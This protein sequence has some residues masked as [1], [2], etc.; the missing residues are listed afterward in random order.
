MGWTNKSTRTAITAEKGHS[1]SFSVRVED[2]LHNSVVLN[3]DKCWFTVRPVEYT[4]GFND[5]DITL[6]T[7]TVLGNGVRTDG[8]FAGAGETSRFDFSV[9]AAELNLDP[10]LEYEYDITFS[11]NGYSMSVAAGDFI[12]APNVT[13]RGIQETFAGIGNIFQVISTIDAQNLLVVTSTIPMPAKGDPGTGSYVANTPLPTTVGNTAT[14]LIS[15]LAVPN[16][17]VPQVGDVL[18]SSIT[19]GVLAT[20]Q[21]ISWTGTPSAVVLTR[22]VYSREALKALLD[23]KKKDTPA[24]SPNLETIDYLW[25]LPKA[26]VPLP[27]GYNYLVG[28]FVMS[29]SAYLGLQANMKLLISIIEVVGSTTL[30]VR[31]KVVFPIFLDSADIEGLLDTKAD[32]STTVNNQPLTDDVMLTQDLVPDGTTYFR[33]TGPQLTK[34]NALPT[35]AQYAND[36]AGKAAFSHG[37]NISDVGGLQPELDTKVDS[38]SLDT[39]WT[40][41]QGEYDAITPK[42]S[43]VLYVIRG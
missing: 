14:V 30:S 20:I 2:R 34:L 15:D 8:V 39:I 19:P 18:F 21:S 37:H 32:A 25:T 13:N 22:Q 43:R 6:G 40:G 9:Q 27:P 26:D 12:I 4:M 33:A 17:R 35:A 28:D 29:H 36:L 10:E 41:T 3:T 23:V 42:N 5:T 38:T 31:T 16:G 1:L 7:K 24:S 11:H